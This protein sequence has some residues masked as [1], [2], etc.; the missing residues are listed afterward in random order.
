MV[1]PAFVLNATLPDL[2]GTW[3]RLECCLGTTFLPSRC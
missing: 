3:L 1:A 2:A